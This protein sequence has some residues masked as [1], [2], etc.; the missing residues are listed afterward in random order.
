[1]L[2]LLACL[3]EVRARRP[4]EVVHVVLH[5]AMRRRAVGD[6]RCA[7][8]RRRSRRPSSR[9][10][11]SSARRSGRSRRRTRCWRGTGARSIAAFEHAELGEP[12]RDEEV[13]ADGAGASEGARDTCCPRDAQ[14]DLAAGAA[15]ATAAR[16]SPASDRR[17]FASSG[18]TNVRPASGRPMRCHPRSTSA[19]D[20]T[21]M[22]RPVVARRC[23]RRR[24]PARR[25]R[26]HVD[27]VLRQPF[28]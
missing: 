17:R 4:R 18:C 8:A 7:T 13:V 12:L 2:E 6:C 5:V 11:R 20:V 19:S 28:Q 1:M 14:R 9:A 22:I 26:I 21:S 15:P 25:S 23:R 3:D 24:R 10:A 27:A 16:R